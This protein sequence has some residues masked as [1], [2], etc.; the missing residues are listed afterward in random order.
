MDLSKYAK[1]ATGF[2]LTAYTAYQAARLGSSPAGETV[3]VDE[4]VGLAVTA[5]L[6]GF[7]VWAVPNR[8][9][10]TVGGE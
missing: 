9:E 10:P 7:G 5:A 2:L 8:Q 1:A 6:V 4:W 3:T